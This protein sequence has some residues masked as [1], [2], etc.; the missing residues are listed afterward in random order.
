MTTI[1]QFALNLTRFSE[2]SKPVRKCQLVFKTILIPNELAYNRKSL[3]CSL[4]L[5]TTF[6]TIFFDIK[7]VL[8]PIKCSLDKFD[9][10]HFRPKFNVPRV[11]ESM[12]D[13]VAGGSWALSSAGKPADGRVQTSQFFRCTTTP[14]IFIPKLGAGSNF[15]SNFVSVFFSSGCALR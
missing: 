4:S 3:G 10:I 15:H 7:C 1:S 14:Q 12:S 5:T 2:A 9:Q 13:H 11:V 6:P 8:I